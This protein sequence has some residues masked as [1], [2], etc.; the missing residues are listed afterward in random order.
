VAT[1]GAILL[2]GERPGPVALAGV[3]L[4]VAGLL[5]VAGSPRLRWQPAALRGSFTLWW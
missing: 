5:L 1:A 2:F 3:G 4:I